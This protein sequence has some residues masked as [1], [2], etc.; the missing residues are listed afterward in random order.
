MAYNTTTTTEFVV[1]WVSEPSGRGTLGIIWSCFFTIFVSTWTVLHLNLP[2]PNERHWQTQVRKAKWM[3]AAVLVPEVVTASAFAQRVAARESVKTMKAMNCPWTMKHAFY[4]NM[5]GFWIQ[6]KDNQPFPIN[7]AQLSYLIADGYMAAPSLTEAEIWDKSKVDRFAKIVACGQIGW[8]A[9][10]CVGRA[11]QSLPITPLELATVGFAIP[12]LATFC[13]WFE[14]P[15]DIETPTKIPIPDTTVQ[16]LERVSPRVYRWWQTPLDFIDTVNSPSF[17]SEIILKSR[18]WPGRNHFIGPATRIRN[19][20][21]ALKYSKLDQVIVGMVWVG[22]AGVHLSAWNF[23]FP[24][25]M[26]LL[27]WRISSLVMAGSMV[28]FWIT[29]NRKA[30]LLLSYLWPSKKEHLEKISSE[31]AKVSTAQVLLGAVTTFSY[32]TAR[33]ILI[34]QVFLAFRKAPQGI[35]ETVDWTKVLPHV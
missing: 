35:F 29:G 9:L 25:R 13:L 34:V 6:P 1:G 27:L 24:S 30:Y 19:D 4:L 18:K 14:K 23:D 20:N 28:I 2:A 5:G 33:I 8:L 15:A 12:S 16:L 7:S 26:E 11:V 22:Y 17:T 3:T 21:F 10:Q 31:R 32:L